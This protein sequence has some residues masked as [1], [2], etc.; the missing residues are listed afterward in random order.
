MVV[1][2]S[3]TTHKAGSTSLMA[4]AS[5]LTGLS[6]S[7]EAGASVGVLCAVAGTAHANAQVAVAVSNV[8]KQMRM[9]I[10]L[11]LKVRVYFDD[12]G[13]VFSGTFSRTRRQ[14][15]QTLL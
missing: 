2:A 9:N 5:A 15:Q 13:P 4:A 3:L 14:E 7:T 10:L 1:S 8:F 12:I 6:A 11:Q